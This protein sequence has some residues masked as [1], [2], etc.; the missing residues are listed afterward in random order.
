MSRLTLNLICLL[1]VGG[2][3]DQHCASQDKL[4]EKKKQ[5]R[6]LIIGDSISVGYT[7]VVED[8]LKGEIVVEHNPGNG[9]HTGIGLEKIDEWLGKTPWDV[10]HFN[11]GL[12][13][14]CYR[15]AAGADGDT[16][17][18]VNG[19]LQMT[20]DQYGKNL[21]QLVVRLKKTKATLIWA[22]TTPV[23]EG[24]PG[25]IAHDELR[26]NA[27]AEEIMKRHGIAINDL[28]SLAQRFDKS[29]FLAAGDVHF[30]KEG[31]KLLGNHVAT[32][33]R[34]ALK[35]RTTPDE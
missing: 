11:W 28:H 6:V 18:K 35:Q 32:V 13:D 21:E 4:T 3:V 30:T 25:R 5:P 24:E 23:P 9:R 27:V 12:H 34:D 2:L 31:Y 10:I 14:L 22:N 1:I 26:Y 17:D 19:R 29:Q 7:P 33:I 15:K 8:V 16:R 20:V